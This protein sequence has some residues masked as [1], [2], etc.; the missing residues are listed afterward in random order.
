[1]SSQIP[2]YFTFNTEEMCRLFSFLVTI[3]EIIH[4]EED[5]T[6]KNKFYDNVLKMLHDMLIKENKMYST[7]AII[8][9]LIKMT[10]SEADEKLLEKFLENLTQI[11]LPSEGYNEIY[12]MMLSLLKSRKN[13]LI[14]ENIVKIM[15]KLVLNSI[16][17]IYE[18]DHV[19]RRFIDFRVNQTDSDMKL[20]NFNYDLKTNLSM[21]ISYKLYI[22]IMKLINQSAK[23]QTTSTVENF[24]KFIDIITAR[25]PCSKDANLILEDLT[26]RITKPSRSGRSQ[27]FALY[28][29]QRPDFPSWMIESNRNFK[30]TLQ[31]DNFALNVFSLT[32]I[33]NYNNL[34]YYLIGI[35]RNNN[36]DKAFDFL[37]SLLRNIDFKNNIA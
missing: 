20:K 37:S 4:K 31:L 18:V 35:T 27:T 15:I 11:N 28:I 23:S 16:P 19:R 34:R 21:D 6:I 8:A 7:D 10:E 9:V 13:Y 30:D 17:N 12:T 29:H 26:R 24:K 32:N 1:M 36:H 22:D 3:K 25:I 14:Y 33:K 5:L 2:N